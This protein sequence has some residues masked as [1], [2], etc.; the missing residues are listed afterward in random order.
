MK[1]ASQSSR[2]PCFRVHRDR[3]TVVSFNAENR[4]DVY[5]AVV[6]DV[7]KNYPDYQIKIAMDTDFSES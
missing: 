6:E 2:I 5:R 7:Q 4:R 3:Y 1:A